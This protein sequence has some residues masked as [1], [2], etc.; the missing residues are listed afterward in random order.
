M[1]DGIT[2]YDVVLCLYVVTTCHKQ[3]QGYRS[4]QCKVSVHDEYY[5]Q[6]AAVCL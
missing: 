4:I 6:I 3:L 2:I 1:N 5:Y